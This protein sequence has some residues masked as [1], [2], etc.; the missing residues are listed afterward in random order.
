MTTDA[1]TTDVR[2]GRLEGRVEEQSLATNRLHESV[3]QLSGRVDQTNVRIDQLQSDMN[4]GFQQVN[5]RVD[6]LQSDMNAGFQQGNA[7]MDQLQS[8][9]M[10]GFQQG[11][12]RMDQLNGRIDR[13]NYM[14]VGVGGGVI[15]ALVGLIVTLVIQGSP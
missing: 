1:D 6:Q 8:D 4:A 14:I 15:A 2:L 9:M 11:N 5:A 13:M 10:A 7:R 3:Q 12:A